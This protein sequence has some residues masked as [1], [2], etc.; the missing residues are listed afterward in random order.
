MVECLLQTHTEEA[1]AALK[2]SLPLVPL[3]GSLEICSE[4]GHKKKKGKH[5][6]KQKCI[7]SLALSSLRANVPWMAPSWLKVVAA[8]FR[9]LL[10]HKKMSL[11]M[12]EVMV[13]C[14]TVVVCT[15]NH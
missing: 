11:L 15:M 4:I 3:K 7:S 8:L 6:H 10:Y 12:M 14:C 9:D 2:A 1:A 5:I 13:D